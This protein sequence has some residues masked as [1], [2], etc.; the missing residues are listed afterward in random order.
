M[1]LLGEIA[2]VYERRSDIE[3]AFRLV[4]QH[5]KVHLLWSSNLRVLLISPIL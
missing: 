2:R 1:L 3:L 5:L 4:K